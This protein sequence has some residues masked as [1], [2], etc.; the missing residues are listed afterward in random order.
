[1]NFLSK[2]PTKISSQETSKPNTSQSPPSHF[3]H[4]IW[5]LELCENCKHGYKKKT[6]ETC[7]ALFS[8]Q[9]KKT[10]LESRR[11]RTLF[12]RTHDKLY[13]MCPQIGLT[14]FARLREPWFIQFD[15]GLRVSV[16]H[17]ALALLTR[18]PNGPFF[19]SA[20]SQGNVA[21]DRAREPR[22]PESC[23]DLHSWKA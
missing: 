4:M 21:F 9:K 1:M 6:L 5:V 12:V 13:Y 3:F 7:F 23:L 10:Q 17:T 20:L 8:F 22:K 11:F 14:Q 2:K 19:V 18:P 16:H 15:K